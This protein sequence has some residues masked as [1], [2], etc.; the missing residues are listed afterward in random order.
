MSNQSFQAEAIEVA[1]SLNLPNVTGTDDEEDARRGLR[2]CRG[3]NIDAQ[4]AL[5]EYREE[6]AGLPK[7]REEL[8]RYFYHT[9]RADVD[10]AGTKFTTNR[11][12][13]EKDLFQVEANVLR[14]CGT[15]LPDT[16]TDLD[17]YF[18]WIAQ[19]DNEP[20]S[21]PYDPTQNDLAAMKFEFFRKYAFVISMPSK[22]FDPAEAWDTYIA[23]M[24]QYGEKHD[25]AAIKANKP[26][27]VGYS[28]KERTFLQEY[29]NY[30]NSRYLISYLMEV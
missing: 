4:T 23:K 11:Q 12:K 15:P 3:R 9:T 5:A 19:N 30:G 29:R 24:F 17:S 1:R 14:A 21:E 25:A 7:T 28:I 6:A 2:F 10:S 8:V 18:R 27:M 13:L 20:F 26:E 22:S 16:I